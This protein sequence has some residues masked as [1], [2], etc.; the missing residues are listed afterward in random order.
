MALNLIKLCVGIESVTQ[1]A[2]FQKRRRA[3]LAAAGLPPYNRHLTRNF[4]RRADEILEPAAGPPGS[5]FWVIKREVR[6]RQPLR[7]LEEAVDHQ[8]RRCCALVYEPDLIRVEPRPQRPFQGW[9]YLT[10]E[11]APGDLAPGGHDD[12]D[13][14]PEEMRRELQALGLI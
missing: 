6:V 9:R 11:D 14:M 7:A 3:E 8:G 10:A 1:L 5:L 2:A 13:E 4:P 12:A